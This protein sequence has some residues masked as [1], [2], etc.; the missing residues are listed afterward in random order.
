MTAPSTVPKIPP[1]IN[2]LKKLPP[3]IPPFLHNV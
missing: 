1:H 3:I 2:P